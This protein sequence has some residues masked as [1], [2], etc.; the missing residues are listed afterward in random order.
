PARARPHVSLRRARPVG[1]PAHFRPRRRDV[2]RPDG[3]DRRPPGTLRGAP[4]SVH[5]GAPVGR[6]DPRPGGRGA[7]GARRASRRGAESPSPAAWLR[8]PPALPHRGRGLP[9]DPSGPPGPRS[10]TPGRL[11]PGL[12][13][14]PGQSPPGALLG[15]TGLVIV[16]YN[17]RGVPA[18]LKAPCRDDWAATTD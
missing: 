17:Q 16:V 18:S 3:G 2:P 4:P 8:V 6:P 9:S 13:S 7:A 11:P 14:E 5:A 1:R 12:T 15:R 10:R